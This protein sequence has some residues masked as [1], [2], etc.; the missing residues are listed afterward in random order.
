MQELGE[1]RQMYSLFWKNSKWMIC[2]YGSL[3][4]KKLKNFLNWLRTLKNLVTHAKAW[5]EDDVK[6]EV[7][8][9]TNLHN[10]IVT[11]NTSSCSCSSQCVWNLLLWWF[12]SADTRNSIKSFS[13][14]KAR[15]VQANSRAQF[16]NPCMHRHSV[17]LPKVFLRRR[18]WDSDPVCGYI[19]NKEKTSRTAIVIT[20]LQRIICIF[21][22]VISVYTASTLSL[23]LLP[24]YPGHV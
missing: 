3:S 16:R 24:G 19:A 17:M 6:G 1:I 2:I 14:I 20:Q 11:R 10:G 22:W 9:V 18:R 7:L 15:A 23:L 21:H 8:F 12:A 13:E 5:S 4:I